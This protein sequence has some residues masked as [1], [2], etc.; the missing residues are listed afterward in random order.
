[1]ETTKGAQILDSWLAR[2]NRGV[3][4]VVSG[5]SGAGKGTL[6]R[7]LLEKEA[8][9]MLSISATTRAPRSGEIDG[10]HYFFLEKKEFIQKI[11]ANSFLEW[12]QVYDNYYGTPREKVEEYLSQGKNVL[13]EID[14]Q[15]A[16]Q[17][18]KHYEEAA[19]I[20][21]APPS[22]EEL[23]KR[24]YGR[25][26]DSTEVIQK[27]LRLASEELEYIDKYDY[28]IINDEVEKATERLRAIVAAERSR[29]YR[30]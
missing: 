15:G 13:L 22:L 11:N 16:L 21:I 25:G 2:L 7:A 29:I 10:V 19:L 1:M 4:I 30:F 14:I 20:F 12:A 9:I 28:C 3:L 26:T 23:A 27:R 8:D 6:C 24:I 5:P 17:V 18:K